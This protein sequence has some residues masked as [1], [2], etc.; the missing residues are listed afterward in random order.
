MKR[1]GVLWPMLLLLLGCHHAH[2]PQLP[3]LAVPPSCLTSDVIMVQCDT[4][5]NPPRCRKSRISYKNN[6]C[7]KVIVHDQR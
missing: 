6:G 2:Q 7:E 3:D 1:H 4:H 5:F